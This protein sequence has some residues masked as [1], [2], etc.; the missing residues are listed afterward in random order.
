MFQ[1]QR[2]KWITGLVLLL[3]GLTSHLLGFPTKEK[4]SKEKLKKLELKDLKK[5][6]VTLN[7][8]NGLNLTPWQM[9]YIY[10]HVRCYQNHVEWANREMAKWLPLAEKSLNQI[11]LAVFMGRTPGRHWIKNLHRVQKECRKIQQALEEARKEHMWGIQM[12]LSSAQKEA[13]RHFK[14]CLLPPKDFKNPVRVGQAMNLSGAINFFEKYRKATP[15]QK[16][17]ME[18]R[19]FQHL[20]K[21]IKRKTGIMDEPLFRKE[22]HR[23]KSILK[24]VNSLSEIQFQLKKNK[25]AK[26]FHFK[27]PLKELE[28]KV[29]EIKWNKEKKLGKE[30]LIP[31]IR[32]FLSKNLLSILEYKYRKFV[33]YKK[34]KADLKKIKGVENCKSCAVK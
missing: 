21:T 12:G 14:A 34:G 5:D 17:K 11:S 31:Q 27:N 28:K 32:V 16:A 20:K 10:R 1:E 33:S 29:K 19:F 2:Q 30:S 26:E 18:A 4:I 8:I 7:L 13:V 25:L 23:L 24:E 3:F 22:S 9:R 15:G 6:I